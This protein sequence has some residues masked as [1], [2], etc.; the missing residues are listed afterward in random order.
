MGADSEVISKRNDEL[1]EMMSYTK[2]ESDRGIALIIAA[3][4]EECLRRI[5]E[6]VLV[7]SPETKSLFEG[8]YAPFGS[9]SGKTQAAFVMGLLTRSERDRIDAVRRV[10]NVFAHQ[11]SASFEHPDIIKI[12]R[13][14]AVDSGTMI[15]RDEF[16]HTAINVTL[17]LLY[18]DLQVARWR[19]EELTQDAVNA[20]H[21]SAASS[22]EGE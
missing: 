9:L 1:L 12:C 13:K 21:S 7:D 18:R 6:S 2:D 10:R 19:R 20:W 15:M 11:A 4:I 5:L 22:S 8:P 3:H 14:P 16:L 17:P